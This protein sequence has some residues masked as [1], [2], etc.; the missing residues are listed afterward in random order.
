MK[1]FAPI[2]ILLI[3]LSGCARLTKDDGEPLGF[4]RLLTQAEILALSDD[5]NPKQS[6]PSVVP[7]QPPAKQD[8][9]LSEDDRARLLDFLNGN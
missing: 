9:G 2:L 4:P 5:S 3:G 6:Q 7:R 8:Q 1:A